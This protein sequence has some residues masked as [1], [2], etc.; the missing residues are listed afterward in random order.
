LVFSL[1]QSD[2][3]DISSGEE[4]ACQKDPAP[5]APEDSAAPVSA[6]ITL[7]EPTPKASKGPAMSIDASV[8]AL[9][10]GPFLEGP[11]DSLPPKGARLQE[12]IATSSAVAPS[13]KRVS[14]QEPIIASPTI[15]VPPPEKACP[16]EPIITS[17]AVDS[18]PP[19]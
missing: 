8:A 6:L 2:I 12:P 10:I 18:P 15:I 7:Q 1:L 5:E 13:S 17:S 3:V 14:P 9:D 4:P 16:Q 19:E 11:T